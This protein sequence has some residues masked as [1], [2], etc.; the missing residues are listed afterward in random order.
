[1]EY[2]YKYQ[3]QITDIQKVEIPMNNKP[4]CVR[5]QNGT[6]VLYALVNPEK[7]ILNYEFEVF[8]T[9][10]PIKSKTAVREYI[11]TVQMS[12]GLVWHIFKRL[13]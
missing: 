12:N 7:E 8:G 5:E 1:M 9:G 6:L 4:L 10:H 3:L 13:V 2:I 11:D